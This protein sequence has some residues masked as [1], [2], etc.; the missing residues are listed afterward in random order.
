MDRI[1]RTAR[2]ITVI[3]VMTFCPALA[4]AQTTTGAVDP[5]RGWAVGGG[6][7]ATT[8]LGDC[9]D[10]EGAKY[11]HTYS[12]LATAGRALNP[13][14]DFSGEVMFVASVEQRDDGAGVSDDHGGTADERRRPCRRAAPRRAR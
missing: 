9:T 4:A 12:V 10:C 3:A 13:R 8:F 2:R 14:A 7:L 11:G 5:P 6:V 1:L